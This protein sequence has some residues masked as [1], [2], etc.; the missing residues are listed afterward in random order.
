[1]A[2]ELFFVKLAASTL[3]LRNSLDMHGYSNLS[4]S[5]LKRMRFESLQSTIL[6]CFSNISII[7]VCHG[8]VTVV[9]G[10]YVVLWCNPWFMRILYFN[11]PTATWWF[12]CVLHFTSSPAVAKTHVVKVLQQQRIVI[13]YLTQSISRARTRWVNC[14]CT[15]I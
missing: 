13:C 6:Y 2:C 11:Y 5:R 15:P 9:F 3:L 12:I 10:M 7:C 14:V 4:P 1:M 8:I